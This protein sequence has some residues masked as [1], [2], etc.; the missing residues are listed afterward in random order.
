KKETVSQDY[1][2]VLVTLLQTETTISTTLIDHIIVAS[3]NIQVT[4]KQSRPWPPHNVSLHKNTVLINALHNI[5][6]YF[7]LLYS[8]DITV[9]KDKK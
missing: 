6:V 1:S 3:S 9:V 7:I 5:A 8:E 2:T 4:R